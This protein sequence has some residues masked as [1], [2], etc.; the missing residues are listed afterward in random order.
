M[1]D[2]TIGTLAEA[3]GVGVETVRFYQRKGLLHE[4]ARAGG[5]RRYGERDLRQLKFIRQA[6]AAG[7]TLAEIGELLALDAGDP[8]GTTYLFDGERR[9]MTSKTVTVDALQPDG[10]VSRRSKAFYFSHQ[11]AVIVRPEAGMTWSSAAAFVLADPNRNNTRML[12]QWLGIGRAGNVR[13]LKNVIERAVV[14]CGDREIGPDLIPDHVSANPPADV[15]DVVIPPE[16]IHF[17]EVI[18]GHERRYIEAALEAAG[19]VQ[20]RAAELLNIKAT[21][22]NEMIKRYD[23]RPRR[24]K[25]TGDLKEDEEINGA[26]D[27]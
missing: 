10:S 12:E 21:T 20:K 4:P 27:G 11:G 9:K 16:G 14:L 25:G 7:F 6:Q 18:I 24:R 3:A 1:K 22:L 15:P 19:G 8:T 23:I 5:I 2:L 26:E 17:R 13:E